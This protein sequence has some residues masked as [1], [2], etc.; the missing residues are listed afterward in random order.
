MRR[1]RI[2]S[3]VFVAIMAGGTVCAGEALAASKLLVRNP[4]SNTAVA[5]GS[6]V[7]VLVTEESIHSFGNCEQ[8]L[9][10]KVLSNDQAADKF[11]ATSARHIASACNFE[12]HFSVSAGLPK[13]TAT[14][15]GTLT[16]TYS[17]AL[18]LTEGTCVYDYKKLTTL[19]EPM[20]LISF[21]AAT[22]PL[23]K[24]ASKPPCASKYTFDALVGFTE[25]SGEKNLTYE[26]LP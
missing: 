4:T 26:L 8:Q 5:V 9:N 23:N 18:V 21:G 3:F 14:S 25:P 19:I 20:T 15:A 10:T 11:V 24:K 2:L 6:E 1:V 17:P 7:L 13:L 22:A 12:P 16:V